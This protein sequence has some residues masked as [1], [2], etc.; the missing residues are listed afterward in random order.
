VFRFKTFVNPN[1]TISF[2]VTIKENSLE[3]TFSCP[4]ASGTLK[5]FRQPSPS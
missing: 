2:Q 1:C 4:E 3:G 5:G